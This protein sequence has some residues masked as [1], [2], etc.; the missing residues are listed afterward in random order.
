MLVQVQVQVHVVTE[1]G[2]VPRSS[3]KSS[4]KGQGASL[5]TTTPE[6]LYSALLRSTY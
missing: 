5:A 3:Q 2:P 6:L 1:P 4:T